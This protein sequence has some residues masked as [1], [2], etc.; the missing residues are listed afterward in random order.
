MTRLVAGEDFDTPLATS[1]L[2]DSPADIP[3]SN[4]HPARRA[5]YGHGHGHAL[6]GYLADE[7]CA[8]SA[9]PPS[10]ERL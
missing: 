4:V 6:I 2:E 5:V 3:A 1:L 10:L 8:E 7:C 9:S